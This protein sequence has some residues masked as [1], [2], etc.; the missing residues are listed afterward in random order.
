MPVNSISI[1]V[2][3]LEQV[4][5]E[6]GLCLGDTVTYSC[7]VKARYQLVWRYTVNGLT[8]SYPIVFNDPVDGSVFN[9]GPFEVV[10]IEADQIG[11]TS[12]GDIRS[13]ATSASGLTSAENGAVISCVGD[14][15]LEITISFAGW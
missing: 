13:T 8:D 5:P 14:Y 2:V 4:S 9:L 11:T 3:I 1:P 15:S 6:G 7:A 12:S 10:L